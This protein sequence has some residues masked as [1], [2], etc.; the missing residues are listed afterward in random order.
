MN[1]ENTIEKTKIQ[2]KEVDLSNNEKPIKIKLTIPLVAS[3][4]T[5]GR[6]QSDI[7]KTCGLSKQ[8]VSAYIVKNRNTLKPL[9]DRTDGIVAQ[10]CKMLAVKAQERLL[11]HIDQSEKKDMFALN[12]ISGTHIDKYQLLSGKAT[13]ITQHTLHNDIA[14][15]NELLNNTAEDEIIDITAL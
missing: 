14:A 13:V 7:A 1:T 12:A 6:T 9:T 8:W 2:K 4:L 15:L 10:A 11:L 3:Y 5:Q